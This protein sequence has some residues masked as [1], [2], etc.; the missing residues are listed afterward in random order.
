MVHGDLWRH[1]YAK[2]LG[3]VR[4]PARRAGHRTD[5]V[6]WIK[7]ERI[8]ASLASAAGLESSLRAARD[9]QAAFCA[10]AVR[11]LPGERIKAGEGNAVAVG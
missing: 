11:S 1:L 2:A 6:A 10:S 7:V 8:E 3:V 9:T 5:T 4:G